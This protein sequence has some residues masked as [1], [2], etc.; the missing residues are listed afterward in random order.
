MKLMESIEICSAI[1]VKI[2]NKKYHHNAESLFRAVKVTYT[3]QDIYNQNKR[4]FV[5]ALGSF[6]SVVNCVW[7]VYLYHE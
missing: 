7:A 4:H 6:I 1:P 2:I 3:K 5:I